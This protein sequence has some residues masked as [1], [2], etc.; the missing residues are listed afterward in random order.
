MIRGGFVVRCGDGFLFNPSTL[1]I[2][3][4]LGRRIG[5]DV[6]KMRGRTSPDCVG[7]GWR[8]RSSR[9]W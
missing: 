6:Q 9:T 3:V 4:R 7:M 1:S 5:I 8:Q 2:G